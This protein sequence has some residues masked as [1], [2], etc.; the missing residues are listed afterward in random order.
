MSRSD[1]RKKFPG[2][3]ITV[4]NVPIKCI[5]VKGPWSKKIKLNVVNFRDVQLSD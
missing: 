1:Q 5:I 4:F 2:V 3:T